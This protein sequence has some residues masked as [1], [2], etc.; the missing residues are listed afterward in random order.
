MKK[1]WDIYQ[2]TQKRKQPLFI[3]VVMLVTLLSIPYGYRLRHADTPTTLGVSFSVKYAEEL[4]IDWK[5]AML[6]LM[7]E[8]EVKNFRLMSYWDEGEPQD[9]KFD[10]EDLDWQMDQA[11]RHNV[12]VS[13]AIGQRQPRWPE[14]HVPEWAMT[15]EGQAYED[16]LFEYVQT[17]VERYKDSP[18]IESYQIENEAANNVF[19]ECDKYDPDLLEREIKFVR[20]L[21]PDATIIT[22]A[23]SQNGHTLRGPV[24]FTDKVGFSIYHN[25]H[26]EAFGHQYGW[27]Y[28][29][30]SHWHSW[31]AGLIGGLKDV[32]IFVHELQAEPWGPEATVNL[33]IEEQNK[34]MNPKQLRAI[35]NYTEQSGIKEM[36]LWGAEWWY[37]R[38][39]EFDDKELWNTVKDIFNEAEENGEVSS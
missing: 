24:S 31:K 5:R 32:D 29:F 25:A 38:L 21:D 33:S 23:S 17:V 19:G 11:V 2:F 15:L 27:R 26:F 12:K 22:N 36:H 10:F 30:P 18:A 9:D 16:E 3:V 1:R 34:T 7:D 35:I 37:W 4:G 13:L 39:T 20:K 8:V 14:C 6:A 28:L